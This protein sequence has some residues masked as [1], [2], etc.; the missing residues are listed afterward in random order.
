[1]YFAPPFSTFGLLKG[2]LVM[3]FLL[4]L[5]GCMKSPAEAACSDALKEMAHR[6]F[7]GNPLWVSVPSPD[8]VVENGNITQLEWSRA[9]GIRLKSGR[10]QLVSASCTYTGRQ[11]IEG[12]GWHSGTQLSVEFAR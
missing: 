2:V 7:S 3:G 6:R 11:L 9:S 8:S 1:M 12:V 5:T 10:G 4:P